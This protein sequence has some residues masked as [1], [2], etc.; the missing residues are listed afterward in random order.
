MPSLLCSQAIECVLAHKSALLKFVSPNDAS[1]NSHQK[2]FYLP[3]EAWRLFTPFA[4]TKH[5]NNDHEVHV[6]WPDGTITNST[7]KWYGVGTRSEYRLT[8]FNRIAHFPYIDEA[9]IGSLLVLVPETT[10]K[11]F[12]HIID[13][14]ED[15]EDIQAALGIEILEKWGAV[16]SSAAPQNS[17]TPDECLTRAFA[18]FALTLSQF[19]PTLCVAVAARQA[20]IACAKNFLAAPSDEKLRALVDAEYSLFKVIERKVWAA[21][22]S[23]QFSSVEAFV[24]AASSI[25]NTRKSRAGHSLEHHVEYLLSEAGIPF[26]RQAIVGGGSKPDILIPGARQY[27]DDA[28]PRDKVFFVALKRTCKDRWSQV[29]REAP[30]VNTKHILTMQEGLSESQINQMT[31]DNVQLIVPQSL[32]HHYP[33]SKKSS[34]LNVGQFIDRVKNKLGS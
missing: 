21:T 18:D 16:Y 3:R 30:R 32:H 19:P 33:S 25:V 22:I 1:K 9:K 8:G 27:N 31:G 13:A 14:D 29:L 24:N 6:H 15:V 17:E 10:D 11:F 34:L 7:V 12:A 20:L 23:K 28:F 2:G 26:D 4:P 5:I